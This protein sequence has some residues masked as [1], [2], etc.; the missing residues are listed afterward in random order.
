MDLPL[1]LGKFDLLHA[2]N[3]ICRL[4]HPQRL[5]QRLPEMVTSGGT[6]ILTTP[7]TWLEDFTPCEFWP[8]GS[9]LEWL[10]ESLQ[11]HFELEMTRDLPFIIREHARKYQLT[12][13]QGSR[14]IRTA[15]A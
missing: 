5:L 8:A 3:L 13:A 9:T 6:L 11:P 14:W 7:C 1:G 12:V 10:K 4:T 2:A 15:A